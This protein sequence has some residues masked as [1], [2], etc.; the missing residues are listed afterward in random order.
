M[1][2]SNR[3]GTARIRRGIPMTDLELN[4]LLNEALAKYG[5]S[6]KLVTESSYM[7]ATGVIM[8]PKGTRRAERVQTPTE[9]RK[10][11]KRSNPSR[12]TQDLLNG[13]WQRDTDDEENLPDDHPGDDRVDM[14]GKTQEQKI[15]ELR[16]INGEEWY[17]QMRVRLENPDVWEEYLSLN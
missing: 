4:R 7:P 14:D 12:A 8:T 6:V 9:A 10:L 5:L 11:P 15:K 16:E 17:Q 13:Y 1:P 2:L 3:V